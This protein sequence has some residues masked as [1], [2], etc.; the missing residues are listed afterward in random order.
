MDLYQ[1]LKSR[2]LLVVTG[3][4]GVGKS[5]MTAALGR[6]LAARG[7]RTLVLEVDPRE[8]LHQL[9]DVPPSG[10]EVTRVAADLY[11][12]NLKPKAVVD[13]L[14][15]EKVPIPMLARRVKESPVYQRFVEGAPGLQ[16]MAIIGHCLRVVSGQAF[17][18]PRID[19]VILDAP[20][21]GHGIYLLTAPRLFAEAITDG[22]FH[23]LAQQGAD[24]VADPDDAGLVI[25]TLAEEMPVQEA[26][27]LR[28][29]LAERFGRQPD[30]LIT[31][32]LY[33]PLPPDAA[34]AGDPLLELW[35]RRRRINEDELAR[36]ERDWQGP[37]VELPLLPIDRG[38]ALI[39]ALQE[40]LEAVLLG[41]R[42][43]A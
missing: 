3:K 5:A 19:T 25:V 18:R 37:K 1:R 28:Q 14:V 27:E 4:G 22:P 35:R 38:P 43:A 41:P 30:L 31:N 7:R 42:G 26:L 13:W 29:A 34:G 40:R 33:P 8:N 9:L 17:S 23:H 36:L 39:G 21:T 10:G 15:D 6:S 2:R 32:G 11:L 20:A 16:E 24:F 12:Q